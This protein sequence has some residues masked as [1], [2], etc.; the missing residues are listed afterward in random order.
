MVQCDITNIDEF[1]RSL[2]ENPDRINAIG[3][4]SKGN[5]DVVKRYLLKNTRVIIY[6]DINEL[7]QGIDNETIVGM[8]NNLECLYTCVFLLFV[9]ST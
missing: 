7:L 8:F 3:F 4:L 5:A 2:R 6:N 9:F 1:L